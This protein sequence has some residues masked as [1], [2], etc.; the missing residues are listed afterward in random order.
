MV[1]GGGPLL[2]LCPVFVYAVCSIRSY[3]AVLC[4]VLPTTQYYQSVLTSGPL[5]G[6]CCWQHSDHNSS[7]PPPSPRESFGI[8]TIV[9]VGQSL[10]AQVSVLVCV[11][12]TLVWRECRSRGLYTGMLCVLGSLVW[13]ECQDQ[14]SVYRDAVCIGKL[15][16]KRV[17]GPGVCI[18]GCCVYWEP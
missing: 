11:L 7:T 8:L 9:V 6:G 2:D 12:G 4:V 5:S 17:P 18:Q 16:L 13:R 15:S 1:S 10:L 14:G 3:V